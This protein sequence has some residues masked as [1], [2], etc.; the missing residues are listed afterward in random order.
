MICNME[1]N[2]VLILMGA[3][4]DH[5]E[6]A[7]CKLCISAKNARDIARR[8]H[9]RTPKGLSPKGKRQPKRKKR[10]MHS[11][12][13]FLWYFEPRIR[14]RAGFGT[15]KEGQSRGARSR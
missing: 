10:T 2:N 1:V 14:S 11:E 9:Q 13:L 12:L 8:Q 5:L 15:R 3:N 6:E 7:Y 4:P